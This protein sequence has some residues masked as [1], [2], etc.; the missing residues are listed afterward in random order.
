[1]YLLAMLS[2]ANILLEAAVVDAGRL[3]GEKSSETNEDECLQLTAALRATVHQR[4]LVRLQLTRVSFSH[5]SIIYTHFNCVKVG[6]SFSFHLDKY[7]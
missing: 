4:D 2:L 7:S 6:L 5:T 3:L 1:M